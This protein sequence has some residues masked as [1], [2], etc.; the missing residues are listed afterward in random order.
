MGKKNKSEL[1][2]LHERELGA[3]FKQI[4]EEQEREK[5]K[6]WEIIVDM[7]KN[8]ALT[9]LGYYTFS[10]LGLLVVLLVLGNI[11]TISFVEGLALFAVGFWGLRY[12]WRNKL[13]V[14][15]YNAHVEKM[16]EKKEDA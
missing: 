9:R 8:I 13:V 16:Y 2:E 10:V 6:R 1:T 12:L 4:L 5:E 3:D 15:L 11:F 14:K 7:D